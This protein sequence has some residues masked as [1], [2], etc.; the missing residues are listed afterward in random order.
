MKQY[1]TVGLAVLAGAALVEAALIPGLVIGGAAVLAPRILPQLRRRVRPQVKSTVR[2]RT[3]P[4]ASL[5][6]RL[7][8]KTAQAAADRLA[9]KQAIAKTITF[10]I[11]VTTLDFSSNYIVLGELTTAAGL[12]TFAL[13]VGPLFYLAHETAWN[14]F[15]PPTALSKFRRSCR[16]GPMQ[17]RRRQARAALRSA[18]RWPRPS[19]SAPSPRQ[20]TSRRSTWWSVISPPQ[21]ASPP[22]ALWSARLF[23]GATKRPG[24]ISRHPKRAVSISRRQQSSCRRR[25]TRSARLSRTQFSRS[26]VMCLGSGLISPFSTR[27]TISV[28]TALARQGRPTFSPSRTIRP[29]RNSISVRRPFC[30]S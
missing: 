26:S 21:Q 7:D 20:W 22:S 29:L 10:R 27:L 19:R 12:S 6:A 4:A 17:K 2:R 30:M 25:Q 13:V 18:G 16:C 11:I 5:P 3:G 1:L 8:L 15:G 14:Y 28:S 9:I 23:I 24:I